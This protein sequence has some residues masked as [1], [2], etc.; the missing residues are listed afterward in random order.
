MNNS[1]WLD[2]GLFLRTCSIDCRGFFMVGEHV[3]VQRSRLPEGLVALVAGKGLFSSMDEHV[4]FQL[5][6]LLC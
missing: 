5:A 2:W 6:R 4:S 3:S 1:V